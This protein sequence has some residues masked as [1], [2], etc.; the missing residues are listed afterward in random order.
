MKLI[1]HLLVG[2]LALDL[3]L[4]ALWCAAI[5]IRD[6]RWDRSCKL[7]AIEDELGMQRVDDDFNWP[8]RNRRES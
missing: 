7:R 6:R 8:P 1:A 3:A 5:E 2:L 4:L